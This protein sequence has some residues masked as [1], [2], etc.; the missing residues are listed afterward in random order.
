MQGLRAFGNS[1]LHAIVAGMV[2]SAISTAVVGFNLSRH[3]YLEANDA[4]NQ[5]FDTCV[6]SAFGSATPLVRVSARGFPLAHLTNA[7]VP[8]CDNFREIKSVKQ[9][10]FDAGNLLGNILFWSVISYFV[11]GKIQR[12]RAAHRALHDGE[13]SVSEAP[14]KPESSAPYGPASKRSQP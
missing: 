11:L 12:R 3:G 6:G 8:V 7:Y 4:V 13:P 5:Y 9:T 10:A 1:I 14:R 2:L